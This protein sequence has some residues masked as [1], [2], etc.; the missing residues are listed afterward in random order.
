MHPSHTAETWE[1]GVGLGVWLAPVQPVR[2]SLGELNT[3][4]QPGH[5]TQCPGWRKR[6]GETRNLGHDAGY[7]ALGTVKRRVS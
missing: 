2:L 6:K 1:V 5:C 3:H 4:M 7:L